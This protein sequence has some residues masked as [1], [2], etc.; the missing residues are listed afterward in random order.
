MWCLEPKRSRKCAKNESP[1]SV[2]DDVEKNGLVHNRGFR[3]FIRDVVSLVW[4]SFGNDSILNP[5]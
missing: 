3:E 2:V 5:L 1:R 4:E